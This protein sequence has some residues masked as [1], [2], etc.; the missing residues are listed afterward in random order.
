MDMM[1]VEE[2]RTLLEQYPGWHVS[3]FTPTHRA[4]FHH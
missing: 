3:L 4:V 1:T 2:L